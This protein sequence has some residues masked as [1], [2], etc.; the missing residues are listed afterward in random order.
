MRDRSNI[1][2]RGRNALKRI[3][4]EKGFNGWMEVGEAL[5]EARD[6]AMEK[7]G[8]TGSNKP[9]RRLGLGYNKE[10]GAILIREKM[11]TQFLDSATRNQ[12]FKI[13][14]NRP[15]IEAYR[16]KLDKD[17]RGSL[18]HPSTILRHWKAHLTAELKAKG[19]P[20]EAAAKKLAKAKI[21][22]E[23][24]KAIEDGDAKDRKIAELENRVGEAEARVI[25]AESKFIDKEELEEDPLV[26]ALTTAVAHV[27]FSVKDLPQ[28]F[29]LDPVDLIELAKCITDVADELKRNRKAKRAG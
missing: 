27:R 3:N 1:Y 13:M 23:L 4:D 17:E 2:L 5:D 25:R 24:A 19:L 15:A 8:L 9:T 11:D 14:A 18:N 7:L 6:E 29:D 21:N 10:F 12:L 28:S 20:T 22:A 26:W 16:A